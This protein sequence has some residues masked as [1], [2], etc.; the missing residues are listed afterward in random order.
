MSYRDALPQLD[1]ELFLTDG[2][3]ETSLIF[4]QGLDLPAFA[5]FVLLDD[6]HGTEELR[7]YYAPYLALARDEGVGFVLESPTWRASPRWG[8]EL[9]YSEEQL[10]ALNRRAIA[11]MEELRDEAG[12]AGAG[13]DQRL[14]RPAGRRLQPDDQAERR[15]GARLPRHPDRHVPRHRRG[16]GHRDDADLRRGGDRARPCRVRCGDSGR[17]LVHRRDRRAAAQRPGPRRGHRSR[18]TRRRAKRPP[19][20]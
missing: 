8:A 18:S 9:G 11:L 2:G 14:H 6:E 1:G 17:H 5:A 12:T 3:I 4:H 10:D 20:T 19:T 16:H 13:R 7:R 15:R